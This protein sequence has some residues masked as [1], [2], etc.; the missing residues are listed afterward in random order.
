[1]RLVALLASA[2]AL[3]CTAPAAAQIVPPL[4]VAV[5]GGTLGVGPEITYRVVPAIAV[6]ASATWLGFGVH[7]PVKGYEYR[8]HAHIANFGGTVDVHPFLNGFRLSAGAR[9]TDDNRVRFHGMARSPQTYGGMT[10]TPE[11]AGQL[12]GR[13]ETRSVSP[14]VTAGYVH[15]FLGGLT[16]GI[17]GGVM[18]H[19]SPRVTRVTATG[20]LGSNPY[21]QDELARQVQNLRDRVDN[22]K[23][24]PVA[25]L[26]LGWRF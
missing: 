7:G 14:L 1:M 25:Q 6:R 19:G 26:S 10:F 13:I 11:Q 18:F 24:Y 22:Y 12:N 23:Y 20:E 21:A 17:D 8:A 4:T 9:S 16:L 2:A 5:T 3:G 15:S